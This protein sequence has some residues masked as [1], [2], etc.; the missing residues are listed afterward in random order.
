MDRTRGH[1][2]LTWRTALNCEGGACVQVAVDDRFILIGSSRQL[3]GPVLEYT[4]EKW[5]EFVSE[6]KRGD[7]DGLLK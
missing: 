1:K 7:F 2:R 3:G 6:V 4:P 5:H